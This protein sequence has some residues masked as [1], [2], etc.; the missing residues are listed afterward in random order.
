MGN[1]ETTA[2]KFRINYHFARRFLCVCVCVLGGGGFHI[3]VI[4]DRCVVKRILQDIYTFLKLLEKT[5][6]VPTTYSL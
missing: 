3:N 2:A 5:A 1:I 6:S 4:V